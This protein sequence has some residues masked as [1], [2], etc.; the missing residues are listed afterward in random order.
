MHGHVNVRLV[1]T[2]VVRNISVDYFTIPDTKEKLSLSLITNSATEWLPWLP[3]RALNF[4]S[5]CRYRRASNLSSFIARKECPIPTREVA[6]WAEEAVAGNKPT[7]CR[8]HH[9][10][11]ITV[12]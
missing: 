5:G 12:T 1:N 6:R 2:H 3:L 8:T 7:A 10:L 9:C 4:G 11:I